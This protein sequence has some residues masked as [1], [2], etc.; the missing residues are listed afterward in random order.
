MRNWNDGVPA[1]QRIWDVVYER[2]WKLDYF[3]VGG[4]G[5]LIGN[6]EAQ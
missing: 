5:E 6:G 1:A 4:A 3:G 2:E